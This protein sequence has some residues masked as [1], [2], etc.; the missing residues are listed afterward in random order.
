[1]PTLGRSVGIEA[2]R[3]LRKDPSGI[4]HSMKAERRLEL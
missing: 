1:M 4:H 2:L 3:R